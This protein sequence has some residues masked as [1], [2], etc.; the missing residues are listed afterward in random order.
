MTL[1]RMC[2]STNSDTWSGTSSRSQWDLP[3]SFLKW[4]RPD[5]YLAVSIA[6]VSP[7]ARSCDPEM[8][9][10]GTLIFPIRTSGFNARYQL[11]TEVRAPGCATVAD[12]S[13]L[14]TPCKWVW[15]QCC[16]YPLRPP[17]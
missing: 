9:R 8:Y 13:Y 17:R 1:V 15:A 12:D 4:F 6:A 3:S 14:L 10:A 11:R 16:V 2:S 7:R 5:T